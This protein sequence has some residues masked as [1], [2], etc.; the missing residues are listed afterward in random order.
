MPRPFEGK[1][2]IV[3]GGNSGIGRAAALR[4]AHDGA[5]VTIAARRAEACSAVVREIEASGG[6]ALAVATDVSNESQVHAM[7]ARTVDTFGGLD[8]AF[9]NAG[10]GGAGLITELSE[11]EWDRMLDTNLKGVWLCMKHQ[12][13]AMIARGG[14]AIVNNSSAA[15]LTGHGLAPAYAASKHG[16]IGLTSSAALQFLERGIRINAVCP[17]VIGTPMVEKASTGTPRGMA[18]FLSKQPGGAAGTPEQVA[19]AV[20]WLCSEGASF[21]TGTAL[22]VD[23]GMLSGFW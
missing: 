19:D 10:A 3:T 9:N 13:P 14:G 7:V 1:V 2:A 11:Q 5:A 21:V 20:A 23:A 12:I 18:W 4:F 8:I 6:R 15:G 16:V 22:R 17:G